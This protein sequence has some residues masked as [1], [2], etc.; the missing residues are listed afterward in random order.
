MVRVW[1]VLGVLGICYTGDI[2]YADDLVLAAKTRGEL[3][4]GLLT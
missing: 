3:K 1:R 4:E 2:H